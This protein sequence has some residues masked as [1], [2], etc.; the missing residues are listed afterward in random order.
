MKNYIKPEVKV[1]KVRIESLLSGSGSKAGG[2]IDCG[3]VPKRDY[4]LFDEENDDGQTG[5]G[6]L[7]DDEDFE[8]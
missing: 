8:D 5:S 4:S 2:Q 3:W 1:Y 6:G 7:W